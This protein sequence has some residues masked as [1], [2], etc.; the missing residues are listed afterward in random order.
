MNFL[1]IR[2]KS[3][4]NDSCN[5]ISVFYS[6]KLTY[7]KEPHK[8]TLALEVWKEAQTYANMADLSVDPGLVARKRG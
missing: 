3:A 6:S 1:K 2:T 5:Q 4:C 7:M 8:K